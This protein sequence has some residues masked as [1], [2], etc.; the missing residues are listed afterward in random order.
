[1]TFPEVDGTKRTDVAFNEMDDED[2]HL[3]QTIMK[4]LPIG[5]ITNFPLDYMHLVCLGVMKKM[6]TLWL[7]GLDSLHVVYTIKMVKEKK[8]YSNKL[9]LRLLDAIQILPVHN[10]CLKN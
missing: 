2:H 5:L 3:G 4:E 10:V 6:I 1:M 8:K 9:N 7:Y